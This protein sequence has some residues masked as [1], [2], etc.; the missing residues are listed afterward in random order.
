VTE[1][2]RLRDQG[3]TGHWPEEVPPVYPTSLLARGIE[4]VKSHL[5]AKFEAGLDEIL[6]SASHSV[7]QRD[8]EE[9]LW[10][11]MLSVSWLTM[12]NVL[13][14]QCR[15]ATEAD[16]VARGLTEDQVRLRNEPDYWMSEAE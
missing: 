13:S 5:I 11:I 12:S 9:R 14:L 8:I 16:I 10:E 2:G 15:Q 3:P 4:D 7:A 1:G 6:G